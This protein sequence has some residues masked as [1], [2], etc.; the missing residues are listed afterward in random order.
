[1]IE[2]ERGVVIQ[3]PIE[4]IFAFLA[5]FNN[6]PKFVPSLVKTEQ[7]SGGPID[8]GTKYREVNCLVL[9]VQTAP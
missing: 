8:L 1:M 4:E 9:G 2:V 3:R 5:D 7:L 6:E